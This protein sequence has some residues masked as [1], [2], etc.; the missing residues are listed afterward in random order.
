M[1]EWADTIVAVNRLR[2]VLKGLTALALV[3]VIAAGC[4]SD[5]FPSSYVDQ[6]DEETGLSNVEQNWLAGCPPPL[7]AE[8]ADDA[9]SICACSYARI[10]DE[11]PFDTFVEANSRLADDP[12]ILTDLAAAD[13]A[14][15]LAIVEI[16]RDCIAAAA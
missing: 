9:A 12:K 15:A 3:A 1:R 14:G 8:F 16:V 11:I 4:S 7:E 10:K 5:G 2:R 13:N 6:V